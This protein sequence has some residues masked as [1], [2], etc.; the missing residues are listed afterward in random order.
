MPDHRVLSRRRLLS[1]AGAAG[2]LTITGFPAISYAQA[3]AI[4]IGH[5]TPRTGFLGTLGEFAVQAVDLSVEEINASGGVMGRKID[6]IKED[7][8]NP[9]TASVKAERLIER[10]K[11]A[12]IVGEISSAS[13]LTIA[14]VAQ[15]TKN[16]YVNTGGNSDALRGA[17]CNK[18][19]FHIE[20]Q[21]SMY[22]KTVGRSLLAKNLV[23]G[24]KWY[25]LTAD[26]AFGHDLLRVAKRFMEANGGQFAADE[27]VPTDFSDF[28]TIL[29]K[30]RSAK[31]DLVVSNLAGV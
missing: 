23:K 31:P 15:R 27:L 24:K 21:N 2:A 12:C 13:C 17:S 8:V 11:V 28:S 10:D 19:M 4:K 1:G 5:L 7:S 25:S 16:L 26:Y 18:Y 9:Q 14:Q 29:T 6:L 30:I 22:V 20:S 3:D